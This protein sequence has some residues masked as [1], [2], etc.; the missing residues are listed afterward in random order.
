M[1]RTMAL[2]LR[3]FEGKRET[4]GHP[5]TTQLLAFGRK[6]CGAD[7]VSQPRAVLDRIAPFMAKKLAA[8]RYAARI[9]ASLLVGMK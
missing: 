8:A 6:V 2:T 3:F 9:P 4:E 1:S 7:G 5:T